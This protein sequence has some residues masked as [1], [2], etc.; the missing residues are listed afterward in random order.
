MESSAER[1]NSAANTFNIMRQ[2]TASLAKAQPPLPQQHFHH[3]QY[4]SGQSQPSPT[5]S[6]V[7]NTNNVAGHATYSSTSSPMKPGIAPKP[8]DYDRKLNNASPAYSQ[9]SN[10]SS[11]VGGSFIG[12]QQPAPPA[13]SFQSFKAPVFGGSNSG[14]QEDLYS[15]PR[16]PEQYYS[17]SSASSTPAP[18]TPPARSFMKPSEFVPPKGGKQVLPS[19]FSGGGFKRDGSNVQEDFS[20]YDS[21]PLRSE[22]VFEERG[23]DGSISIK[24]I[25]SEEQKTSSSS[26]RIMSSRN[27]FQGNN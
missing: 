6:A 2:H 22:Q 27:V 15:R 26:S 5:S 23:A 17:A 11:S 13:R 3:P 24:R 20:Q 25:I 8:T 14:P 16:A 18:S 1:I 7:P 12:Q 4:I 21:G 19:L 9:I 10:E